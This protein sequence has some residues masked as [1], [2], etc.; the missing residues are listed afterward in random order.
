MS[1]HERRLVK[2]ATSPPSDAH[3]DELLALANHFGI[4]VVVPY[5][6]SH[7]H[8]VDRRLQEFRFSEHSK[9]C[10][11]LEIKSGVYSIPVSRGKHVKRRYLR[12]VA[13]FIQFTQE[14]PNGYR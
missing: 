7:Y 14:N 3:I 6:S 2:W 9:G 5:K 12:T 8:L 13:R 1:R 10:G 11:R 4:K